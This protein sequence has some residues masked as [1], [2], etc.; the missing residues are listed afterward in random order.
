MADGLSAA[1]REMQRTRGGLL[2]PRGSV[3]GTEADWER[4]ASPG[5]GELFR[6]RAKSLAAIRSRDAVPGTAG[7]WHLSV[8]HRDR[9]PTWGELGFARDCLLPA[10]VWLM[11]AH[12]PRR[13]WINYD[14]RV[15]HLW[16]F[17]D[18]A[19][20]ALFREEGEEAQRF[21]VNT[22]DSGEARTFDP[23]D[24]GDL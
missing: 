6:H 21:G 8:S 17:S 3:I 18:P 7:R 9:V 15:L 20:I 23:A 16:E 2:V 12:P 11:V 4:V 13:Y 19:L 10:D 14:R 1:A 24:R 5:Y 22:P